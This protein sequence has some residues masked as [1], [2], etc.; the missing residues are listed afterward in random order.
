MVNVE[1]VFLR[2]GEKAV[3]ENFS[4]SFPLEGV[5]CLTGPSGCGKTTLLRVVAG[6]ERP[7]EGTV[8]GI[9]PQETAFLFQE[10]RLLPWRTALQNIADVLPRERREEAQAWLSW[11]ELAGE[12]N[13]SVAELSG[14]MKRRVALA[15]TLALGGRLLILDEPFQGIDAKLRG[16]LMERIRSLHVP[17]LAVTHDRAELDALA[18]RVHPAGRHSA[19][20][21]GRGR[22]IKNEGG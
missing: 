20:D 22:E 1:K 3:L 9:L 16:R 17:A 4:L 11:V 14:G 12:E 8:T 18:D 15:R 7:D 19:P 13:R 5:T 10:D 21:R 2:L 6:L